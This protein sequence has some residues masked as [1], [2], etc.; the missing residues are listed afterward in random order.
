M[1]VACQQWNLRVTVDVWKER[2][3]VNV[4]SLRL[5]TLHRCYA[6]CRQY[7]VV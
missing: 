2:L 6:I 4:N 3:N 1:F 7:R 5:P